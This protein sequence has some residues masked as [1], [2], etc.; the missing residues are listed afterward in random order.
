MKKPRAAEEHVP[1]ALD[2]LEA[3][4]DRVGGGDE[5][6]LADVQR[7]ALREMDRDALAGRVARERDPP[8]PER[9]G[10]EEVEAR[11]L[12]LDAAGQLPQLDLDAGLLPE[13]DVVLEHDG[14]VRELDL[15]LGDEL[16]ADVVGDAREGL[17]ADVGR[18]GLGNVHRGLLGA[19]SPEPRSSPGTS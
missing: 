16:A 18:D 11:D 17:V 10:D 4:L 7:L 14:L 6:V 15:E 12:A 9:A 5:L 3:V 8:G 2:A 19:E 13:Q 1:D